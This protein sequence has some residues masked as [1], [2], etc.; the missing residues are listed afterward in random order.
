MKSGKTAID[1]VWKP[2]GDVPKDGTHVL[3]LMDGV[4]IEGW[5][6]TGSDDHWKVVRVLSHGCGCCSSDN[7]EPTGWMPLPTLPKASQP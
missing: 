3:F 4:V 1:N 2:I 7:T 5:Y 6:E